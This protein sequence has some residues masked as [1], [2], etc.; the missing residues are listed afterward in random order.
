MAAPE[1][2]QARRIV[3]GRRCR[4]R[5]EGKTRRHRPTDLMLTRTTASIYLI[6]M[7]KFRP[8]IWLNQSSWNGCAPIWTSNWTR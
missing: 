5:T 7:K 1:A 4:I 3:L 2:S 6:L 8:K